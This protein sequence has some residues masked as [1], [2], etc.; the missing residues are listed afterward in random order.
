MRTGTIPE[1]GGA[2]VLSLSDITS[3]IEYQKQLNMSLEK[4]QALLQAIPDLM[5]VLSR[6]G[7][8]IDF[9]ARNRDQLAFPADEL[10]AGTL[11]R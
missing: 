1:S 6:D 2:G 3:L 11:V 7:V 10:Q 5:F 9:H 4:T 8:Y